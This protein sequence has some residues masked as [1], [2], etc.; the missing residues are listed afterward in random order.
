MDLL[1][2]SAD[3]EAIRAAIKRL[4]WAG[5]PAGG[6]TAYLDDRG[7]D[8]PDYLHRVGLRIDEAETAIDNVDAYER[9]LAE[10][11]ARELGVSVATGAD[12]DRGG[13][14]AVAGHRSS[15]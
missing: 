15:R 1:I 7:F 14:P 13:H 3:A 12:Y 4:G 5:I 11:L 6:V 10:S 9:S 8:D 2:A